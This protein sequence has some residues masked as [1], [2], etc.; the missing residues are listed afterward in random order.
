MLNDF[1]CDVIPCFGSKEQILV[2]DLKNYL[3]EK[4]WTWKLPGNQNFDY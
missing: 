3:K 1:T 2:K 4:S